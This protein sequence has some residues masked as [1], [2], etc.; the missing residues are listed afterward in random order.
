M[1]RQ[2]D[3]ARRVEPMAALRADSDLIP[4]VEEAWRFDSPVQIVAR[5]A[6]ITLDGVPERIGSFVL[7]DLKR[8][9]IRFTTSWFT[10]R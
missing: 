6:D 8:L 7:H 5:M 4:G 3:A 1:V 2:R 10:K 9:P